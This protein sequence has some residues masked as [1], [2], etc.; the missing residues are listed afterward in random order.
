MNIWEE[1]LRMETLT[2]GIKETGIKTYITS[3][4]RN[5]NIYILDE[6]DA[7]PSLEYQLKY[8]K[9]KERRKIR[10]KMRK[11]NKLNKNSLIAFGA[12]VLEVQ[13]GLREMAKA[14]QNV[15]KMNRG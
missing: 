15:F 9:P 5:N 12:S 1:K 4:P 7:Y 13:K 6:I 3:T 11:R 10:R 14:F 2:P 8:S